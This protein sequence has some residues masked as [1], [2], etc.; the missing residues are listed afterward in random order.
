MRAAKIMGE[1]GPGFQKYRFS[2]ST[3]TGPLFPMVWMVSAGAF[4]RER[5]R[6]RVR[7]TNNAAIAQTRGSWVGEETGFMRRSMRGP[8]GKRITPGGYFRR[9][10]RNCG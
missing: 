7:R 8:G 1:K 6:V 9:K 10:G 5:T 4:R 2:E 3:W